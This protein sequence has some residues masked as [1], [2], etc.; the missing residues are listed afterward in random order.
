MSVLVFG[1][2]ARETAI[3]RSLLRDERCKNVEFPGDDLEFF[4]YSESYNPGI[5]NLIG[6]DNMFV[7]K[8]SSLDTIKTLIMKHG[9]M[10]GIIGPEKPLADGLVDALGEYI[11]I[12]GPTRNLARI[13]SSK[14]WARNFLRGV[15]LDKYNPDFVSISPLLPDVENV[16][17]HFIKMYRG[18]IVIKLD[19][20]AGGK[21]VS[22]FGRDFY[23]EDEALAVCKRHI[24]SNKDFL[25][26]QCL[27]GLEFSTISI[28]DGVS[29]VAMPSIVDFKPLNDGN[30]G[31]NTGSMGSILDSNGLK[32]L[33]DEIVREAERI[34]ERVLREL[35]IMTGDSY[36]GFLY[37]S[38]MITAEGLKVIEYNCRLGDPEGV[39]LLENMQTSLYAICEWIINRRL[40]ENRD[41]FVYSGRSYLCKYIVP[42]GYPERRVTDVVLPSK[43]VELCSGSKYDVLLASVR[44]RDDVYYTAGSR[45]L[46]V[47]GSTEGELT[48]LESDMNVWIETNFKSDELHYRTDLT[49][50]Y[51]NRKITERGVY[52]NSGVNIDLVSETL[53]RCNIMIESTHTREVVKNRGG[54]GGLYALNPILE[55][56]LTD[57]IL[58]T[59]TDG[60]GTKTEFVH[61][62]LGISGFENI[63][64]D[65]VNH[66]VNDILV[67][68]ASPLYFVDYFATSKFS[69]G[70][71][72]YFLKGVTKACKESDTSL[73]GGET[74]EMP[75]IYT[76]GS[77][78][79]VGTITGIIDGPLLIDGRRDINAGDVVIGLP[80]NGLHTNGFSLIRKIYDGVDLDIEYVNS[81]VGYHRS[82]LD[83]IHK[84]REKKVFIHGLCHITGGGL[85]DNPPRVMAKG[86][87]IKYDDKW[88]IPAMY[89][90]I[91]RDAGMTER[92]LK[93]VFN[94]GV[95]MMIFID[96]I[97]K[98]WVLKLL[99]DAFYLGVV[100]G[101][102]EAT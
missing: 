6:E 22:V 78:D 73:I 48:E 32:F 19:G 75:G 40:S 33:D 50:L 68:G 76:S 13:E 59:S 3:I 58:V 8:Y 27:Y 16:C 49:E 30:T 1:S 26:E 10:L 84:L 64:V 100:I 31:P 72:S 11:S 28:S 102:R 86:L 63:G 15:G 82:Y 29:S 37:G 54:F 38:F 66:C 85:I 94:C 20:L 92:E 83:E 12:I 41:K 36:T 9:I 60:V 18:Q 24:A 44:K 52:E 101:E 7:G 51:T 88:E 14:R 56:D 80:S 4:C 2:G 74:A 23:S 5:S 47:L 98:D 99:D 81:L 62:Y 95:G 93:K 97:N 34:N 90:R 65:L 91:Q 71:F 55:Y 96:S 42:R 67:Q 89:R 69:P 25:L 70:V 21:G 53:K 43:L 39:L 79:V 35:K 77:H 45:T 17:S 87:S 61:K 46:L 57:P